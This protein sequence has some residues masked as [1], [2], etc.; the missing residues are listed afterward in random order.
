[1]ALSSGGT[2]GFFMGIGA[3]LRSGDA[4]EKIESE[5]DLYQIKTFNHMNGRM[6]TYAMYRDIEGLK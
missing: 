6:M 1:M 3:I 5:N 4:E 2:F